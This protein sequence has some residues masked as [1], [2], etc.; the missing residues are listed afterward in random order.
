MDVFEQACALS[1]GNL[2]RTIR[3]TLH[4]STRVLRRPIVMWSALSKCISN[5]NP[6]V[7]LQDCQPTRDRK[8]TYH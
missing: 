3:A 7:V 4:L 5:S 8:S 2:T 6:I 1:P